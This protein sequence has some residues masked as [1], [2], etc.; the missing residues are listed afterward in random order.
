MTRRLRGPAAVGLTAILLGA[1]AAAQPPARA[2]PPRP[3]VQSAAIP[4]GSLSGTVTDPAGAPVPGATVAVEGATLAFTVTGPDGRFVLSGLPPGPYLVR[5]HRPGYSPSRRDLVSVGPYGR[6]SRVLTLKPLGGTRLLGPAPEASGASAAESGLGRASASEE[7]AAAVAQPASPSDEA[8]DELRWRVRHLRRS[9]LRSTTIGD[10]VARAPV[11]DEE[12]PSAGPWLASRL[13]G[14][15][16]ET[17]ARFAVSLFDEGPWSGQINLLTTTSFDRPGEILG[18]G[19]GPRGVA[20]LAIGAPAGQSGEWSVRGAMTAGDVTSWVVAGVYNASLMARHSITA[21]LSYS[22]QRY[23]G[24]N[25]AALA[26]VRS[27]A[28]NVG[29]LSAFDSWAVN[30][31]LSLDYGGHYAWYDYLERSALFSPRVGVTLTPAPRTWLRVELSQ[32]MLAPGAEEFLPPETTGLWLPPERTFAPLS[33]SGSLRSERTRQLEITVERELTQS[34]LIRLR[35]AYQRVTDQLLTVFGLDADKGS[36]F[37]PGHYYVAPAGSLDAAGWGI[38]ITRRVGA[39]VRGSVDYHTWRARWRS[40]DPAA[41]AILWHLRGRSQE[42]RLHDLATTF[43]ADLPVTDTKVVVVY[44]LNSAF[45]GDATGPGRL[46]DGRFDVQLN[47]PLPSRALGGEWQVLVGV[48]N[49]FREPQTGASVYDELLV[50]H[51]PKR[52]LGGLLVRF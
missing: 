28:R 49:L 13:V 46:V 18:T 16:V 25:P 47:Q 36:A 22:T 20:Y 19:R 29:A 34:A 11:Q 33:G 14:R 26:A 30:T 6:V 17:S 39:G 35:R 44:R 23:E 9:V 27:E 3:V 48:R 1:T 38:G 41:A 42:E 21:G 5:A 32:R 51:P 10:L 40:I 15:A 8:Q 52:I 12:A 37:E 4:F 24:G 43:E 45:S 2:R 31:H 50:I 7:D